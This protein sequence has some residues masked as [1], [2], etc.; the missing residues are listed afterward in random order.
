MRRLLFIFSLLVFLISPVLAAVPNWLEY[1]KG[2]SI[3][4][5]PENLRLNEKNKT[6]YYWAK[7]YYS[8][9]NDNFGKFDSNLRELLKK[10]DVSYFM[11]QG[12][13]DCSN[14]RAAITD[15]SIYDRKDIVIYQSR[16]QQPDELDWVSYPP[17]RKFGYILKLLCD[18]NFN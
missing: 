11:N 18:K 16:V 3:D 6:I 10:D 12:V 2:V 7:Y 5:N 1:D 15:I 14:Y 17:Q 13:V 9:A 8:D 4:I